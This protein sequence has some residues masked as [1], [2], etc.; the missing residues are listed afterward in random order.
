[1]SD[2]VI[3]Y[4][5]SGAFGGHELTSVHAVKGVME[6]SDKN[7]CYILSKDNRRLQ[8]ELAKINSNRFSIILI[9]Y[10]FR[11]VSFYKNLLFNKWEREIRPILE[12]FPLNSIFIGVQGNIEISS[13]GLKLARKMGF[14]TFSF[15]PLSSTFRS[16]K[17]KLA[18]LRDIFTSHLY[19]IPHK[20]ITVSKFIKED[21]MKRKHIAEHNIQV[22]YCAAN[23]EDNLE[24]HQPTQS[25]KEIRV[26]LVGRV[27]FKHKNQLFLV[28]FARKYL[29]KL[30]GY[31][32]YIIGEGGDLG[33]LKKE[34]QAA[35]LENLLIT[36]PWETDCEKLYGLFDILVIP[37]FFEGIPLVLYEA[38]YY[39]KPIIASNIPGHA[40]MLH[41]D[42]L[43]DINDYE[44]FYEIL[45]HINKLYPEAMLMANRQRILDHHT[46]KKFG[47]KFYKSISGNRHSSI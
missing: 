30:E 19:K 33:A 28:R 5:D 26:A 24:I 14:N 11:V 40:E 42:V 13:A 2:C 37:S 7:V 41:A 25:Y 27:E 8:N 31:K 10:S 29:E 18:W 46:I 38:M 43:F 17:A 16:N 4:N 12:Q 32:F 15:I 1:M 47:E 34:I 39:K 36:L 20:I 6:N 22:V 45:T 9:G 44:K 21:L 35:N 23:L 3:F